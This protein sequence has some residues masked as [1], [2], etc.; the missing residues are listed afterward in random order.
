M[1]VREGRGSSLHENTRWVLHIQP[2]ALGHR[3]VLFVHHPRNLDLR[4]TTRFDWRLPAEHDRARYPFC[5]PPRWW[6]S[7]T[8]AA[9]T[10]ESKPAWVDALGNGWARPAISGGA[11][12]HWDVFISAPSTRRSVGL[13]QINVVQFGAPEGEGAPGD[14]HHVPTDK[15][16]RVNKDRGWNCP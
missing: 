6:K 4:W 5:P 14:L 15:A 11:G 10:V 9:R 8:P 12:Y 13:S 16:G 7:S 1:D 3:Q 2:K